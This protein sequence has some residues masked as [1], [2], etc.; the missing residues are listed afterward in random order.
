MAG[1]L[2]VTAG[3]NGERGRLEFSHQ[4]RL[5]L[6]SNLRCFFVAYCPGYPLRSSEYPHN[7]TDANLEFG[8]SMR[9]RLR[10]WGLYIR[11]IAE[12]G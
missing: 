6:E 9:L 8:I 11:P 1:E 12:R 3:I 7:N 5:S 10:N 4:H 2:V